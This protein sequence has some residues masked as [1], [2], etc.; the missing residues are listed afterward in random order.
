MKTS[1]IILTTIAGLFVVLLIV[2]MLVM[3]SDMRKIIESSSTVKYQQIE[4]EKFEKLDFSG[5]WIVKIKAGRI[6]NLEIGSEGE[7]LPKHKI[8]NKKG[9]LY[10]TVDSTNTQTLHARITVPTLKELKANNGTKISMEN[11]QADSIWFILGDSCAFTSKNNTFGDVF[12]RTTGEATV[13]ITETM[14]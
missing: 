11:Y 10:L 14:N 6:Y 1:K 3:R 4:I 12:F 5:K 13:Q 2:S 7:T 9:I 8:D